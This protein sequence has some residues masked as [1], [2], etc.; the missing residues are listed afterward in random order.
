MC[1]LT[2][3]SVNCCSGL[4]WKNCQG[5]SYVATGKEIGVHSP[6]YLH[7]P[8]LL[9]LPTLLHQ[10]RRLQ[11]LLHIRNPRLFLNLHAHLQEKSA[12]VKERTKTRS[13]L[14]LI[15]RMGTMMMSTFP[16]GED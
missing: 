11:R 1:A 16:H 4:S 10:H 14:P 7:F 6:R 3:G 8:V 15:P 5:S 2:G 9:H 12:S 13:I